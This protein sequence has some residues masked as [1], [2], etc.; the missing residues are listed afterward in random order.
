MNSR[1][2]I[3]RAERDELTGLYRRGAFVD[4]IAHRIRTGATL[5][6]ACLDING[7]KTINDT[8][9]HRV[10]DHVLRTIADRID[11]FLPARSAA[12]RFGGDEFVVA[13]PDQRA[14]LRELTAGPICF[15]NPDPERSR[16][17]RPTP[18][19]QRRCGAPAAARTPQSA[20]PQG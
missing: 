11:T 6:V 12:A 16:A 14:D 2:R 18:Y 1:L 20:D 4:R 13:L 15:R 8:Y 19:R 17:H 5:S 10:G 3:E 9:S 7:V